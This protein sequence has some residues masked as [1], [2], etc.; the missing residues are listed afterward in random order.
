MVTREPSTQTCERCGNA[1]TYERFSDSPRRRF[2]S[3]CVHNPANRAPKIRAAWNAYN[4]AHRTLVRKRGKATGKRCYV[5]DAPAR[6][7]AFV[8]WEHRVLSGYMHAAPYG[9]PESFEPVCRSCHRRIDSARSRKGVSDGE[10][11]A[12]AD[13]MLSALT[14]KPIDTRR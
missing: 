12:F 13:A 8:H 11:R 5:C 9:P 1:F 6:E 2:C 3:E 14:G 10:V 7:W 4:R